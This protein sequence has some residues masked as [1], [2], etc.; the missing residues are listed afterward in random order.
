MVDFI[1]TKEF[2]N[3]RKLELVKRSELINEELKNIV[4]IFQA[5]NMNSLVWKFHWMF[6]SKT[7]CGSL[8]MSI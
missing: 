5:E 8:R 7:M 3:T 1:E 6:L 2:D 4:S